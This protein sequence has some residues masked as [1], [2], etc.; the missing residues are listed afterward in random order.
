[1]IHVPIQAEPGRL[2]QRVSRARRNI[3][4]TFLSKWDRQLDDD[5]VIENEEWK[6]YRLNPYLLQV[7]PAQ[8]RDQRGMSQAASSKVTSPDPPR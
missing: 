8:L 2:R 5:D 1:M 6:G 7:K 4:R 3:A